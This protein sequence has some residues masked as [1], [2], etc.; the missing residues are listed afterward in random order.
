MLDVKDLIVSKLKVILPC[1]YDLYIDSS[2]SIPCITYLETQ[3]QDDKTSAEAGSSRIGYDIKVWCNNVDDEMNYSLQ[4]D[5]VMRQ[6]GFKRTNSNE[7]TM[8]DQIC[9]IL[10]YEAIGFEIY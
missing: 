6:L 9:K 7:L 3:N 4:V 1:Y 10:H 8:D 2:I 5:E